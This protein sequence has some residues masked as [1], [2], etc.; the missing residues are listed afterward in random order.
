MAHT[1]T[2]TTDGQI[3]VNEWPEGEGQLLPH[4][5]SAIGTDLVT[6]ITLPD[7]K[8]MWA[9]DEALLKRDPQVNMLAVK[10]LGTFGELVSY[11]WGHVVLDGGVDDAGHSLPLTDA[12]VDTLRHTLADLA[13]T[14]L[15]EL[16]TPEHVF[17]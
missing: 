6:T 5:Y 16:V 4:L 14:P 17:F 11:V 2:I 9:D 15:P 1:L 10:L 13:D 3:S 8:T 7:G 12:E